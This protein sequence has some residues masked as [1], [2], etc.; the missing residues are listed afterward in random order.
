M[1]K[2]LQALTEFPALNSTQAVELGQADAR[3]LAAEWTRWFG[4]ELAVADGETGELLHQPDAQPYHDWDTLGQL[5][6]AAGE[7]GNPEVLAE[8]EPLAVLAIPVTRSGRR[9]TAVG[10]FAT[11]D[12]ATMPASDSRWETAARLLGSSQE[13]A[14]H[15]AASCTATSVDSLLR[16]AELLQAHE[17]AERRAQNM[18]RET[19]RLAEEVAARYEEISLLYR[20][21]QNLRLS[22]SDEELG[23]MALI[24]LSEVM[25]AQSL[26]LQLVPLP[27]SASASFAH[28]TSPVLLTH[29]SRVVDN[30]Q[31]SQ[32]LAFLKLDG[33][34]RPFVANS[35][36]TSGEDWPLRNVRS[37]V[38]VPLGDGQNVFGWLAALNHRGNDEFGTDEGQLLG[39]VA[40]ILGI[41]SGNAELYRQQAELLAGVIRALTSAI[42]AK[43][44]YTCGH[45]DRVSR[46]AVRLGQ[47]LGCDDE[48]LNRLYLSGLLHDVGKIGIDE[49]VLRKPGRLTPAEYEHIKTHPDIGYNILKDVKKLTH[50][51]PGVRHHHESW[52]GRG[53]PDGL[54][55]EDIP[56][57][58][59]IIA[60]ADSFDAMGSDRP[61]RKGMPDDKLDAIM[62]EGAG[63]QWDA[64]IVEAFFQVRSEV[65]QIAEKHVEGFD[66][67]VP[68]WAQT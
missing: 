16:L 19:S 67:S 46:V 61:Y 1:S 55:G 21:T 22:S 40:T 25:S 5:A 7:R 30:E 39:S 33:S 32:L 42:D 53:Y 12:A 65:R 60:V 49:T 4:V 59:R 11:V 56:L 24:S 41:H 43:D 18:E 8:E 2:L 63:K 13:Q 44:P 38:I 31:F 50:L 3:A 9:L 28:R 68:V 47:Q 48:F 29:G 15:W 35:S 66:P 52:D 6:R 37:V 27:E 45:S 10:V 54:A 17:S 57:M 58:A 51:L 14:R 26:V 23:R 62:Q 20:L 34:S 36:V 64:K